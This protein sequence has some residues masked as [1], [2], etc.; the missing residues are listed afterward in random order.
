MQ[1]LA[2]ALLTTS[3]SL[4]GQMPP[5]WNQRSP[6]GADLPQRTSWFGAGLWAAAHQGPPA[7]L[8]N[9]LGMGNAYTGAGIQA[10]AGVNL[11]RWSFA[12]KGLANTDTLGRSHFTVYQSHALY[13]SRSGW[14]MGYEQEPLVWGYGLNGGYLLG[15]AS[16]PVPKLRLASP[17]VNLAP[18]GI[19]LGNWG[20][21]TFWG[22]LENGR[23]LGDNLQDGAVK[24]AM[25]TGSGDPQAPF[26]SGYRVQADFLEHKVE[27]YAN[28]SVI[29]G[30]TLNGES[31]TKGYTVAEYLTAMTGAK[32]PLAESGIDWNDPNHPAPV[33]TNKARSTGNF[34]AGVRVHTPTLARWLSADQAWW[35]WSRGSKG[36]T[37]SWATAARRPLYSLAWD[38]KTDL[39]HLAQGNF[40]RFLNTDRYYTPNFLQPNDTLGV[41][42]QWPTV[43]LGLEYQETV[44]NPNNYRAFG[45]NGHYPTGFYTYGDPL[46]TATGGESTTFSARLEV[47]LNP[48]LSTTTW[49]EGGARPF[50]D[51]L[52]AWHREHGAPD[53]ALN[54][55]VGLQHAL[56]W[57]VNPNTTLNAGAAWQRQASIDFVSGAHGNGFRWFAD[58]AFRWARPY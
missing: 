51:D 15:E 50:R 25:V 9:A 31:M 14:L 1:K 47:D 3:L 49:L 48:R 30:G 55:W 39:K 32:D 4:H 26:F 44:N 42:I 29:W 56:T 36:M 46:G 33:Y 37:I 28:L 8:I 45:G 52:T 43:R 5:D 7:T 57:K 27:A 12:I 58:L 2:L 10:E 35:Y 24:K 18:F 20:F 19:S 54:R 13:R 17:M 53:P 6:L 16:R 40:I 41:L 23:T 21:Q 11:E 34:D 38:T 22:R